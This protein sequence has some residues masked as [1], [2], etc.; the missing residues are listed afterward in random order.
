VFVGTVFVGTVQRAELTARIIAASTEVDGT[1]VRRSRQGTTS[2]EGSANDAG[3]GTA[4]GA[5]LNGGYGAEGQNFSIGNSA[6]IGILAGQ[7]QKTSDLHSML[8]LTLLNAT[9]TLITA[10]IKLSAIGNIKTSASRLQ[11][12]RCIQGYPL[13]LSFLILFKI[14]VV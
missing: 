8:K 2:R 12:H 3:I 4:I 9:T 14:R 6:G 1:R 7:I 11:T 13:L 5:T 10:R